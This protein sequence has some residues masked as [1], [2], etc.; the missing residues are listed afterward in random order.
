MGLRTQELWAAARQW[1][2]NT[3]R[4]LLVPAGDLQ[5]S[6]TPEGQFVYNSFGRWA[7]ARDETVAVLSATLPDGGEGVVAWRGPQELLAPQAVLESYENALELHDAVRED[8]LRPPQGGALHAVIGYWYST[9]PE[10]GL[11]VMP[12]GT[13]KTETML[14]LLVAC[15]PERLLV[16]VP[17]IALRDQIAAKFESL[18]IL[19]R[20]KVVSESALRPCVG[21][22]TRRFTDAAEAKAFAAACNVVVTTPHVLHHCTPEARQ[23]LLSEFS[24]LIVDEAHHA[25]ASTWTSVIRKFEEQ[26]VVNLVGLGFTAPPQQELGDRW[27]SNLTDIYKEVL[28]AAG[29]QVRTTRGRRMVLRCAPRTPSR[30]RECREPS[31]SSRTRETPSSSGATRRSV[32]NPT[33][34]SLSMRRQPSAPLS[35]SPSG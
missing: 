31:P 25:P 10:P 11:V 1:S 27:R 28:R 4:Q 19:P 8:G 26:K 16:L 18:G 15:R 6:D 32:S 14:A 22:V 30:S 29:A 35:P 33:V 20:Q 23:A 5:V 3:V 24:H 7:V 2:G 9:L 17:S 13:G 12:T 34:W 21:R